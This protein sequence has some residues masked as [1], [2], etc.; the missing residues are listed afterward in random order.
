MYNYKQKDQNKKSST[1]KKS[2]LILIALV[3]IGGLVGGGLYLRNRNTQKTSDS[4]RVATINYAPATPNEKQESNDVKDKIVAQ[5]KNNP[6]PSP[7]TNPPNEGKKSVTP[8]IT[9]TNGSINAFV[10]GVFEEGGVCTATFTKGSSTLS[11]T[12]VGFQNVSYTQCA[13]MDLGSGFL[14]PGV[15][16][17]TVSYASATAAGASASQTMEV[18]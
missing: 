11:K 13:P 12:S 15:W 14:S 10:S 3:L 4:P 18:Q 5:Q 17:V 6:A 9:N 1:R 8:T 2:I 16:N 7:G